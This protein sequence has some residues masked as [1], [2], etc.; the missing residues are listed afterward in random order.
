[1]PPLNTNTAF[2]SIG[3]PIVKIVVPFHIYNRNSHTGVL[4]LTW[5]LCVRF[6]CQSFQ[7]PRQGYP[8]RKECKVFFHWSIPL[9]W[10]LQRLI[11]NGP[12]SLC[13]NYWHVYYFPFSITFLSLWVATLPASINFRYITQLVPL[14]IYCDIH[15]VCVTAPLTFWKKVHLFN[16]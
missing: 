4:I 12:L 2:P 9:L 6:F 7:V 14:H 13:N 16:P 8:W 11:E 5:P 15:H 3:I 10:D 1:M